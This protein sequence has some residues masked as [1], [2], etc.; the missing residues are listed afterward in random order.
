M[1]HSGGVQYLLALFMEHIDQLHQAVVCP[2]PW[3]P[4]PNF[5]HVW[6]PAFRSRV[7][8]EL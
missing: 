6:T 3:S 5:P 1:M 2:S 4:G 7:L 8:A